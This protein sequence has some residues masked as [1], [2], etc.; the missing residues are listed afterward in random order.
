MQNNTRKIIVGFGLGLLFLCL[1]LF[2]LHYIYTQPKSGSTPPRSDEQ[3]V[4]TPTHTFG[5]KLK[6][7]SELFVK[8]FLKN[9]DIIPDTR[10]PGLY[11]LGNTISNN[12]HD[13]L[14]EY[15]ITYDHSIQFFKIVL[16]QNP[17]SGARRNAET[18]LKQTLDISYEQLCRLNYF[19]TTPSTVSPVYSGLDIKF[20]SCQDSVTLR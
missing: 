5:L 6:D 2:I 16:L 10:N 20:S 9:S 1:L 4:A 18:Y 7:S 11:Y 3:S 8:D 15:I 14:P 19:V 17:L 12:P 13:T